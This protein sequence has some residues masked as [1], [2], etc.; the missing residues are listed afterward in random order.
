M[1]PELHS[2][3]AQSPPAPSQ[4]VASH[5]ESLATT[6]L[7]SAPCVCFFSELLCKWTYTRRS[8]LRLAAFTEANERKKCYKNP[9]SQLLVPLLENLGAQYP[10]RPFPTTACYTSW[11][12]THKARC[13]VR[14]DRCAN[15]DKRSLSKRKSK[16]PVGNNPWNVRATCPSGLSV[17]E[18]LYLSLCL[19]GFIFYLGDA[20]TEFHALISRTVS[21]VWKTTAAPLPLST[22]HSKFYWFWS[23]RRGAVVNEP[24]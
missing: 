17:G 20:W 5:P 2:L 8:R 15:T 11:H 22:F 18:L 12:E 21:S 4:A 24:D 3:P 23:S 1:V 6:D 9:A 10:L 19:Y 13:S 7:F 16:D 14:P